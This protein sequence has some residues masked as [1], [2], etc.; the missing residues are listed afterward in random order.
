MRSGSAWRALRG[1]RRVCEAGMRR[2]FALPQRAEVR[3]PDRCPVSSRPRAVKAEGSVSPAGLVGHLARRP[4]RAFALSCPALAPLSAAARSRKLGDGFTHSRIHAFTHSRFA[5][6]TVGA[7][8]Y[9]RRIR[10]SP[11]SHF[12]LS[13]CLQG[14]RPF[15][16]AHHRAPLCAHLPGNAHTLSARHTLRSGQGPPW[17]S[18]MKSTLRKRPG[19]LPLTATQHAHFSWLVLS[20]SVILAFMSAATCI[21]S[22]HKEPRP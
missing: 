17:A 10:N 18:Q 20:R 11:F 1:R 21:P 13:R 4:R 19:S 14:L 9:A 3:S 12:F 8:C 15:S 2:R 5:F 16:P 7:S 6:S 22:V